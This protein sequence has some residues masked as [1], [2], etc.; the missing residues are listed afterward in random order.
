MKERLNEAKGAYNSLFF[1]KNE[2]EALHTK[3][4]QFLMNLEDQIRNVF[5]DIIS[6]RSYKRKISKILRECNEFSKRFYNELR[7]IQERVEK[8]SE[9]TKH[10]TDQPEDTEIYVVHE[11]I[12]RGD[13]LLHHIT[14]ENNYDYELKDLEIWC[15]ANR[16]ELRLEDGEDAQRHIES[17]PKNTTT[18]VRFSYKFINRPISGIHGFIAFSPPKEYLEMMAEKEGVEERI[19]EEQ[20]GESENHQEAKKGGMISFGTSTAKSLLEKLGLKRE[21]SQAQELLSINDEEVVLSKGDVGEHRESPSAT[22][23]YL[24]F[25]IINLPGPEFFVRSFPL[26]HD[27]YSRIMDGGLSKPWQRAIELKSADAKKVSEMVLKYCSNLYLVKESKVRT[28]K[29]TAFVYWLSGI[30]ME[31]VKVLLT[32]VIRQRKNTVE[33]GFSSYCD[34]R[35]YV[36]NIPKEIIK[37]LKKEFVR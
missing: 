9:W 26:S 27:E 37:A 11:V 14:I 24:K 10:D 20:K 1:E 31:K 4:V 25:S 28:K 13:K 3:K 35:S 29:G 6:K 15:F 12:G 33:V 5:L 23:K 30:A 2:L 34:E 18:K 8:I 32:V 7:E 21:R 16:G 19:K 22:T 36:Q 17:I